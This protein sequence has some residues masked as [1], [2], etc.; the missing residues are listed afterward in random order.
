M[1]LAIAGLRQYSFQ[2]GYSLGMRGVTLQSSSVV[3]FRS[4]QSTHF[5]VQPAKIVE[6]SGIRGA[7]LQSCLKSRLGLIQSSLQAQFSL[8]VARAT[9]GLLATVR[10]QTGWLL[11]RRFRQEIAFSTSP[12]GCQ[13][14]SLTTFNSCIANVHGSGLWPIGTRNPNDRMFPLYRE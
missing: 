11:H 6:Q 1:S 7:V 12:R 4:M 8:Q 2:V 3:R 9:L 13:H 14:G 10:P 5:G